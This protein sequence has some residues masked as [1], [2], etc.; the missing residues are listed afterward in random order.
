MLGAKKEN[1]RGEICLPFYNSVDFVMFPD[2]GEFLSLIIVDIRFFDKRVPWSVHSL[3]VSG[4][5]LSVKY[6][7]CN[8]FG[9]LFYDP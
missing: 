3:I 6:L 4:K 8:F 7:G 2:G 5:L 1:F 9:K